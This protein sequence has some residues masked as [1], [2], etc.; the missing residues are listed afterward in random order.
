[1][2]PIA[3]HNPVLS[4]LGR[5]L[6][7]GVIG[8][9]PGSFIGPIHRSAAELDGRFR[10]VAGVLSSDPA[11]SLAAGEALGLARGR[12]Y[13]S[14]SE[15][16]AAETSRD[17][18][19]DAVAVMTPNDRHLDD[20]RHALDAGLD[21]I[22]D[23][24]LANSVDD[25]LALQHAVEAS[26]RVFCLTHNYSGYPMVREARAMVRAG[27]IG[28]VRLVHAEYLQA[29][30][31]AAV[32]ALPLTPK[33][34]WK[35]DVARSG[36]SLVMGDIGTHA[37]HLAAFVVASPVVAVAADIG[38]IVPARTVD[39]TASMLWR[40]ENGAR[41]S[42]CVSQAAAGAE[43]DI[44]IR[45]Y[46]ETGMLEWRHAE[47]NT[48]LHAPL[49]DALRVLRRGD[50]FLS[51]EARRATRIARGHPEGFRESF[52]NLYADA[53]EAIVGRLT[54]R[55]VDRLALDFPTVRDGVDGM[56]FVAAALES[57]AREGSWVAID[58]PPAGTSTTR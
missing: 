7:L 10:V 35:L 58:Q 26:G 45:V 8:G 40:F 16:L 37:H 46:G 19:L 3:A 13:R 27:R 33:L 17:D 39:D 54:G 32:E 36:P 28:A 47:P 22:C 12:A 44:R 42:C 6:R 23:K 57:S 31:A 53:A 55:P 48:L 29:G 24:P 2:T 30:M 49:G 18:P 20:C 50:P 25:C 34:R 43:N 1:M 14:V 11:R 21:L 5:P 9:G 4:M 38:A 51:A 56:R 52:A 41:G 15:M